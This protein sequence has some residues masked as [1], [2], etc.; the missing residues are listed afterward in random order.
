MENS[1]PKVVID[2]TFAEISLIFTTFK[3]LRDTDEIIKHYI[4]RHQSDFDAYVDW[5]EHEMG[6]R[7]ARNAIGHVLLT[8]IEIIDESKYA[9]FILKYS[10]NRQQERY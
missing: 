8:G 9:Y 2:K 5:L 6:L 3:S 4:N 10:N 7:L 1:E